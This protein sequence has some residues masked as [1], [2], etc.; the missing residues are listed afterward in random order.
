MFSLFCKAFTQRYN[1][2]CKD[3][4]TVENNKKIPILRSPNF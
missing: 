2:S 1:N 3:I 4:F